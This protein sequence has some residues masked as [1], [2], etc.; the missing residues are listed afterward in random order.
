MFLEMLND[1]QKDLFMNL[2]IRA[3][4]A[5]DEVEDSEVEMLR[6]FAVEMGLEPRTSTDMDVD[7]ILKRLKEVCGVTERR[8]ILFELIGIM[9]SDRLYDDREKEFLLDV[10]RRMELPETILQEM[11]SLVEKYMILYNDIFN[12]VIRA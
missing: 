2:A 12:I 10:T 9:F 5:N 6:Q 8:I 11:T 4:E 3:A 1:E 7:E